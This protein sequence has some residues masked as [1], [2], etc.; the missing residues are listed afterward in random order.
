M[1]R[2]GHAVEEAGEKDL[3]QCGGE[4]D[5]KTGEHGADDKGS[6]GRGEEAVA[7]PDAAFAFGDQARWACRSTRWR[8]EDADWSTIGPVRAEA[9][10][11]GA[12][13]EDAAEGDE[14]KDRDEVAIDEGLAA[15]KVQEE[16]EF[17]MFDEAAHGSVALLREGRRWG[18]AGEFEV[19]IFQRGAMNF[20]DRAVRFFRIRRGERG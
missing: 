6:G 16:G 8:A 12:V 20:A 1:I 19:N 7:P 9:M 4:D 2:K 18:V 13:A 15:L 17:E 11:R 3:E 14:E 10:S 5:E